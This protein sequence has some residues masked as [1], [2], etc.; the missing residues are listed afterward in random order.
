MKYRTG[1]RV[2]EKNV[3]DCG[4]NIRRTCETK[5]RNEFHI[6]YFTRD[7]ASTCVG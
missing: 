1:N 5:I 2:A 4:E 6:P 3:G 7:V